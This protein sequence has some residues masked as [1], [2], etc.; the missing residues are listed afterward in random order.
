MVMHCD[1]KHKIMFLNRVFSAQYREN[2]NGTL[3]A[4]SWSDNPLSSTMNQDDS[5]TE[6]PVYLCE[7]SGVLARNWNNIFKDISNLTIDI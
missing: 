5:V 3:L 2:E 1:F 4:D 7:T 6:T